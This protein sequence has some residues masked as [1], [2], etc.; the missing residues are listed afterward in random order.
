MSLGR[1]MTSDRDRIAAA[2]PSYEI[3][4]EIGRGAWGVVLAA[5]HR[6]LGRGVAIKQLPDS[7][8]DNVMVQR[9]FTAE[10]RV[11]AALDHPHIVP[12]FD[13][14]EDQGLCLL[15]MEL[16]PGGTVRDRFS[17]PGIGPEA[18]C[19]IVLATCAALD[20]AHGTGVLHRDIKPENLL[21]NASGTLKVTDF[22]IAKVLGGAETVVTQTGDVLGTP[23]YMAPE[24]VTAGPLTPATDV[25]AVATML[26]ELLSGQ[27]PLS[28]EG[29]LLA[30][31]YRHVYEQPT[32]LQAV[33]PAVPPTLAAVV[34]RAL[35]TDPAGRYPSAEDF[36]VAV[37]GAAYDS[38]GPE[39]RDATNLNVM[40]SKRLA[41][42]IS[43][44]PGGE[45]KSWPTITPRCRQNARLA[46][47]HQHHRRRVPTH[48]RN[49]SPPALP[50]DLSR[51]PRRKRP[52]R[53]R[54]PAPP[55]PHSDHAGIA[56]ASPLR[57]LA[58]PGHARTDGSAGATRPDRTTGALGVVDRTRSGG[59]QEMAAPGPRRRAGAGRRPR[60]RLGR[61][62]ESPPFE[63][64]ARGTAAQEPRPGRV[65][66]QLLGPGVGMGTRRQP[67]R[68]R[69]RQLPD[70]RLPRDRAHGPTVAQHVFCS[71]A[72]HPPADVNVGV[73]RGHARHRGTGRRGGRPL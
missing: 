42:R 38:W 3:G 34:M 44:P 64:S 43:A 7:L 48:A 59:R 33:A 19:S 66:R 56:V 35:A 40:A 10:A 72:V 61:H 5:R 17:G 67:G 55:A 58:A 14:V 15:V 21:F 70:Q 32:P 31:L 37:A 36:G 49:P 65:R 30:A 2:L 68:K 46:G 45:A 4:A 6:Q 16:L 23:A 27:L 8:A 69:R 47:T 63:R 54:P 12:I 71:L 26:Y 62:Q 73:G 29:G 39:W 50:A 11:L 13:Y 22:G 1:R 51:R 9:R 60:R 28:D 24:Q 53:R 18:A 57:R 52:Q 25:Y 20:Y 41:Q